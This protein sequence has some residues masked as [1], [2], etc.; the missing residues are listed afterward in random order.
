MGCT[1]TPISGNH[2]LAVYRFDRYRSFLTDSAIAA[3]QSASALISAMRAAAQRLRSL[4]DTVV[5]HAL[6]ETRHLRVVFSAQCAAQL[7]A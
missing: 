5:Q 2:H 4:G 3:I 1:S 6:S 7:R